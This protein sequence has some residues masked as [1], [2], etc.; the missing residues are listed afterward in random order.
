M[1]LRKKLRLIETTLYIIAGMVVGCYGSHV[2][3]LYR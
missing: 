3:N 2:Y 1:S